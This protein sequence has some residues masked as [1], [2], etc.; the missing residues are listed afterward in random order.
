LTMLSGRIFS[1]QH[2]SRF[3]KMR[4]V[5]FPIDWCTSTKLEQPFSFSFFRL[6]LCKFGVLIRFWEWLRL[7]IFSLLRICII[8]HKIMRIN[9]KRS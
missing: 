1:L 9:H 3:K 8:K 5:K 7:M 4:L 2:P 6:E